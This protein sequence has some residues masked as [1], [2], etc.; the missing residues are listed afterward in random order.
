MVES[1]K[2]R[3]NHPEGWFWESGGETRNRTRDTRIFSALLYQLSYLAVSG[4]WRGSI[5]RR[6]V[7]RF[8]SIPQELPQVGEFQFCRGGV[9]R[10][11]YI[12]Q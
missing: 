5:R 12:R 11:E 3:K 2:K 9:A 7:N 8:F 4:R 10:L 6:L 1:P